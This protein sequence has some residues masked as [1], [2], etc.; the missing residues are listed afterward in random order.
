MT[1]IFRRLQH[2]ALAAG[3]TVALLAPAPAGAQD[4]AAPRPARSLSEG[5]ADQL[6]ENTF[7][8]PRERRV[9]V[10]QERLYQKSGRHQ[11]TPWFGVNPFD[12]LV[13]D[14]MGGLKYHY[15][16]VEAFSVSGTFGYAYGFEKPL[17][18]RLQD[19]LTVNP[20]NIRD[21][22]LELFFNVDFGFH[23]I[24]GKFSL[25][26]EAIVQYDIGL[27]VGGG[28]TKF[29]GIGDLFP[30]FDAGINGNVYFNRWLAL[31]LD[32]SYYVTIGRTRLI[33]L[34]GQRESG[35]EIRQN[36]YV[37]LGL[38]F[39]LPVDEKSN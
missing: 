28:A 32:I 1:G 13:F 36:L 24:Y 16:P 29:R 20:R 26:S 23:P 19:E 3:L 31:H 7:K 33:D 4:G 30:T 37:M 34:Q 25:M 5:E 14:V 2:V 11:L 22:K 39:L 17:A 8:I 10:V 18:Q 27:K 6:V 9:K 38:G 35:S 21:A 12:A 15:Y